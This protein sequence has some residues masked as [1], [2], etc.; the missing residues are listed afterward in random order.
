MTVNAVFARTSVR[1]IQTRR[2]SFRSA[3]STR[4][5]EQMTEACGLPKLAPLDLVV[6]PISGCK[7]FE[8]VEAQ[9]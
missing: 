3:S 1:T 9:A 5:P 4:R 2:S 6:T 7:G 8:S